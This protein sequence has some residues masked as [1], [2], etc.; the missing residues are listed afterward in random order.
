[1]RKSKIFEFSH[2][3]KYSL[4]RASIWLMFTCVWAKVIFL[5]NFGGLT[6][7]SY[8][9][10]VVATN[11]KPFWFLIPCSLSLKKNLWNLLEISFCPQYSEILPHCTLV[12][13][14]F[15]HSVGHLMNSFN[16]Q[17]HVCLIWEIFS[18]YFIVIFLSPNF[19]ISFPS[20]YSFSFFLKITLF[21]HYGCKII[22]LSGD[23]NDRSL[24]IK[25]NLSLFFPTCYF[26][27]LLVFI[28][29]VRI[30]IFH[31]SSLSIHD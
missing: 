1:M 22:D 17:T 24:N 11:S 5:Q 20:E 18:N 10:S 29:N 28:F 6:S 31:N 3:K 8:C 26:F 16:L 12:W 4:L 13:I 15:A 23:N 21:I 2:L 27:L 30:Q 19:S 25:K 7:M 14:C 9:I